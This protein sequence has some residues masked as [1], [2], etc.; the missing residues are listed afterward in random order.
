MN[1]HKN[2]SVA[3]GIIGFGVRIRKAFASEGIVTIG[4]LLERTPDDL[5]E[6]RNFGTSSLR[7]VSKRLS[8]YGL[9]LRGTG[10]KETHPRDAINGA[11]VTQD[12]LCPFTVLAGIGVV[13][14]N[15][16]KDYE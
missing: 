4:D 9:Y 1:V 3:A 6:M 12:V 11:F 13:L 14:P 2:T 8:W 7:D 15:N 5:L 10:P 16:H